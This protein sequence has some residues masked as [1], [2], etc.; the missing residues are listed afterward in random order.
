[1]QT[2][3]FAQIGVL[4]A[5]VAVMSVIMRLLRQPLIIGHIFTGI[6]VGPAA[7]DIIGDKK[8]IETLGKFGITLLLFIVGLGLNPK[9]IKELGKVA[10][11]T[12]IG[13]VVF[14]S[15][16]GF[17]ILKSLSFDNATSL[18]LS[19]GLSFSSTIVILKLLTDKKE[20]NK[21]H[22]RI[23]IGFL[24]VQDIIATFALVVASASGSDE[25]FRPSNLLELA[26]KGLGLA[27]LLYLATKFIVKPLHGFMAKSQE[28]LFLFA[29][30]WGFGVGLIFLK[31]DFSL[32]VGALFAGVSLSSMNYAQEIDTRLRP[33]RDFFIVVFFIAL[34][35]GL[36]IGEVGDL[37]A[38]TLL[39]SVFVLIGNPI[40][41]IIMMGLL[42]YTKK[43]SFKTSLA[44]AQVS[45]FSLIFVL[46]GVNN[47]QVK[48]ESLTLMTLVALVT[49]AL[50]SY[51]ITYSD[52]LYGLFERYLSLFERRKTHRDIEHTRHTDLV[53]IGFRKGGSDVA[54]TMKKLKK[55][56]LVVD[57]DP[58]VI[59]D[60]ELAGYPF[61]YGDSTSLELLEELSLE[62]AKAIMTLASSLETNELI[63]EFALKTNPKIIVIC[64][65][66]TASDA[67]RLYDL[68]AT[69]VMLPHALGT[70]KITNYISRHGF[71]K[72]GLKGFKNRHLSQIADYI[73]EKSARGA[74]AA[75]D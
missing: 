68:G 63:T 28:L 37:W 65:A 72:S 75:S 36:Q 23:A 17:L 5:M 53:I 11:V 25:G 31:M 33:L 8:P 30:S 4:M 12:G 34:G 7:L 20:Q 42:G 46:L 21:L 57:Y 38:K 73:D 62:N 55:K 44:V 60:V 10:L 70:E 39:L 19:I 35:S 40:I 45:E 71:T 49:F 56:V 52:F 74:T 26:V 13:Q 50:S 61:V 29:I 9:V 66:N 6:I 22:G 32:E 14:T 48:P 58:E 18:Y 27:A 3:V 67:S 51:L 41:V 43:T 24:L 2:D 1:M 15:V 54:M 47:G 69:Y 59:E 16:V 64:S